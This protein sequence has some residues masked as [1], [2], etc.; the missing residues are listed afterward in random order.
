MDKKH[1][2]EQLTG[3]IESGILRQN[4]VALKAIAFVRQQLP[5][6]RDDPDRPNEQSENKLNLQLCK[7]LG[8]R[9][10]NGCPMVRFD[11][12]EY[13]AG[14]RSVDLSASPVERFVMKA[15]TYR[16]YDPIL[17]LECKRLPAPSK[18]REKEYVTGG[19]QKK[20]GGIQRF[21]LKLHGA[22]LDLT[23]MIGYIQEGSIDEWHRAINSWILELASDSQSDFCI[24]NSDEVL[25]S[26]DQSSSKGI[27]S[28]RSKHPRTNNN[29]TD[30]EIHHLWIV[31]NT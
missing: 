12:E 22:A 29:S 6:W 16:I 9:A 31:M 1:D 28:C 8:S 10:R 13:Q 26:L 25:G 20:S 24:W 27:A 23:V 18:D 3:Q 11:H 15:K 4:T 17:V 19:R 21:K 14:R 5:A 2:E 30:I 7:F